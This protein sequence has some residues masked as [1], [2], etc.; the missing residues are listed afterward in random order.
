[1]LYCHWCCR[2]QR[3]FCF[4]AGSKIS[5]NRR[6]NTF[7]FGLCRSHHF[8]VNCHIHLATWILWSQLATSCF[9]CSNW[10][11]CIFLGMFNS[12][13]MLP[14][15]AALAVTDPYDSFSVDRLLDLIIFRIFRINPPTQIY[16]D[17]SPRPD[18][19]AIRMGR[20][21]P[22]IGIMFS[23]RSPCYMSEVLSH[24]SFSANFYGSLS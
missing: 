19:P 20:P 6:P 17:R 9:C 10:Y 4:N 2:P 7:A 15:T 5:Q 24:K 13:S 11:R 14:I 21:T 16:R 22:S 23:S 8:N 3:I 1:M 12:Y 18:L